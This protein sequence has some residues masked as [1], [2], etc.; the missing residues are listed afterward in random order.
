M[1]I[2]T[3]FAKAVKSPGD[4]RVATLPG[5]RFAMPPVRKIL[6]LSF[7]WWGMVSLLQNPNTSD[8]F[9]AA[10]AQQLFAVP[11]SAENRLR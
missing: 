7:G 8:G 2:V 10:P 1:S 5:S 4:M 11:L 3:E 9:T 6:G